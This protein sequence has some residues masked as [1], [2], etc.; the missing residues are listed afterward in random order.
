MDFTT[1]ELIWRASFAFEDIVE[2]IL[3]YDSQSV[4]G[5]TAQD[6]TTATLVAGFKKMKIVNDM[7]AITG[8]QSNYENKP[9]KKVSRFALE[10]TK[11]FSVFNKNVE[12]ADRLD[13]SKT[14]RYIPYLTITEKNIG[15]LCPL[16]GFNKS[17]AVSL[18]DKNF[19]PC[20]EDCDK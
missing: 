14:N 17:E 8:C 1:K 5:F 16:R 2:I 18:S 7:K 3:K 4:I 12:E 9:L 6:G 19:K 10:M 15:D 13:R 20:V 11:K